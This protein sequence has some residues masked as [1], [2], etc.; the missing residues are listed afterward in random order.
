MPLALRAEISSFVKCNPAVGAATEPRWHGI[1]CLIPIPIMITIISGYIWWQ[2]YMAYPVDFTP[3]ISSRFKLDLPDSFFITHA[4]ISI[5]RGRKLQPLRVF[6]PLP[7]RTRHSQL[8][9]LLDSM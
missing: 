8:P 3:E 5:E 4:Y 6:E 1:Y 2:R 7:R 9:L